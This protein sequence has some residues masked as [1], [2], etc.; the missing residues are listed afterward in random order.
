[1]R[2]FGRLYLAVFA[3]CVL[4][5][6]CLRDARAIWLLALA[7]MALCLSV[8]FMWLWQRRATPL[9]LGMSASWAGIGG[10]LLGAPSLNGLLAIPVLTM[11]T[12]G[13]VLHFIV[14]QGSFGYRGLQ[15]LWA[16]GGAFALA[17]VTHMFL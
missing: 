8:T 2:D 13:A 4:S 6:L 17:G 16:I 5:H 9:A 1:M 3:L 10:V 14:I 15:F 12:T 7:L 11:L